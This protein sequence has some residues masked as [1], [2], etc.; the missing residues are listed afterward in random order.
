VAGEALDLGQIVRGD[1]D[2]GAVRAIEQAFDQLIAHQR[3][4]PRERLVEYDQPRPVRQ[5]RG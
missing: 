1:E 3:V 4:E 2:G 5:R